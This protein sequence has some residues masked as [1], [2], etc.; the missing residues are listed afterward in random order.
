MEPAQSSAIDVSIFFDVEGTTLLH[1]TS[2]IL[3]D[4]NLGHHD[5]DVDSFFYSKLT[6]K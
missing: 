1:S 2:S 3:E 5:D 4:V 6:N